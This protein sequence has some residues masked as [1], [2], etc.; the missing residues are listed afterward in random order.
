MK[1][2]FIP[3]AAVFALC[4]AAVSVFAYDLL[5]EQVRESYSALTNI[6]CEIVRS[7]ASPVSG[8]S[9]RRFRKMVSRVVFARGGLLH[10]R[11]IIPVKRT[12]V[13]DGRKVWMKTEFD[14]E[15]EVRSVEELSP[16][17]R[18]ELFSVPGTCDS[19]F[20]DLDASSETE[21]PSTSEFPVR[22]AFRSRNKNSSAVTWVECDASNRVVS[23]K[24]FAGGQTEVP[25]FKVTYGDFTE[26]IPGVWIPGTHKTE[27]LDSRRQCLIR[28]FS[29]VKKPGPKK[30][31][32]F[33]CIGCCFE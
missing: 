14:A 19:V 24:A 18:N 16:V 13:C 26:P 11:N 17:M 3:V 2:F 12:V 9:G 4:G 15:P 6:S 8:D 20:A 27:V 23:V 28:V 10:V 29:W 1:S 7:G 25:V 32:F 22:R 30:I 31:N 21:L 5:S 33:R